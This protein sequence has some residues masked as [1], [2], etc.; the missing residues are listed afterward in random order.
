MFW[1]LEST[2]DIAVNDDL[3]ATPDD[4]CRST[5]VGLTSDSAGATASTSMASQVA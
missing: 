4:I 2:E 5:S 3:V 1:E